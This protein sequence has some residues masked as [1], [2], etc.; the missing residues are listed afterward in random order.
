MPSFPAASNAN[1]SP[2]HITRDFRPYCENDHISLRSMPLSIQNMAPSSDRR[3]SGPAALMVESASKQ[4][5]SNGNTCPTHLSPRDPRLQRQHCQPRE[6]ALRPDGAGRKVGP[7]QMSATPRQG[8]ANIEQTVPAVGQRAPDIVLPS[9]A[10]STPAIVLTRPPVHNGSE[11]DAMRAMATS[12]RRPELRLPQV[13]LKRPRPAESSSSSSSSDSEA[14]EEA[15]EEGGST[16]EPTP[17]YS[18]QTKKVSRDATPIKRR[19]AQPMSRDIAVPLIRAAGVRQQHHQQQRPQNHNATTPLI[20]SQG[21]AQQLP[22]PPPPPHPP[23]HR[24]RG[25][26]QPVAN[27]NHPNPFLRLVPAEYFAVDP[28]RGTLPPD[29]CTQDQR[30]FSGRPLS[31]AMLLIST[32]KVDDKGRQY[33][34]GAVRQCQIETAHHGQPKTE[35]VCCACRLASHQ[36]IRHTAPE[37]FKTTYWPLC[38]PCGQIALNDPYKHERCICGAHWLCHTC[39]VEILEKARAK[40]EAE[41]EIRKPSMLHLTCRCGACVTNGGVEVLQCAG[42]DGIIPGKWPKAAEWEMMQRRRREMFRWT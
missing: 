22:R 34:G 2:N 37:L 19:G 26:M 25:P 16:Y 38:Q 33:H 15:D 1:S 41:W 17:K 30:L 31:E 7:Q 11:S 24:G 14:D 3:P 8:Q 21:I 20:V 42:C 35:G 6:C 23:I 5:L 32:S 29:A 13:P 39:R 18:K 27:P 12:L 36:H 28:R 10:S 4:S 9:A 40:Y